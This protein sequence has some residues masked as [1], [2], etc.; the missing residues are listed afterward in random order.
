MITTTVAA[1]DYVDSGMSL[2]NRSYVVYQAMACS[3]LYVSLGTTKFL[4]DGSVQPKYE[5]CVDWKD[6]NSYQLGGTEN[7]IA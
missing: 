2:V 5:L 3:D 4:G 6:T 7:V 1:F